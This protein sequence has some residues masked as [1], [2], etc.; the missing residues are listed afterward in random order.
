MTHPPAA[1]LLAWLDGELPFL[2]RMRVDRHMRECAQCRAS[3]AG[4]E[5][6][7]GS[8]RQLLLEA[9]GKDAL[10]VAHA[11]WQFR[12][13]AADLESKP[14]ARRRLPLYAV[15]AAGL[16]GLIFAL[17]PSSPAGLRPAAP[18]WWARAR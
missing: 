13:A 18:P 10:E 11:R 8:V 6:T 16:A 2:R 12:Q 15:A 4:L 3:V 9:D 17:W 5:A 7:I 14:A 1:Q